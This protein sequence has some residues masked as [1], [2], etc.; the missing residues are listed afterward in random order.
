MAPG[1]PAKVTRLDPVSGA[2]T[3]WRDLLPADPD[4]VARISPILIAADGESYAYTSG[5]FVSTL[6]VVDAR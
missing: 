1:K 5:R 2:R 3:P 4:G 6:F